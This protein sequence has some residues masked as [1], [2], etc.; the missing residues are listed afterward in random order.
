MLDKHEQRA[1]LRQQR[2]DYAASLDR[3]T[4]AAFEASLADALEPLFATARVVAVV[5]LLLMVSPLPSW[6]LYRSR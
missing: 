4:R 1:A 3:A 6:D 5:A 2:R